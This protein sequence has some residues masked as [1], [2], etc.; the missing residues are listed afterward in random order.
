VTSPSRDMCKLCSHRSP[1]QSRI[2]HIVL[3]WLEPTDI[4]LRVK[5]SIKRREVQPSL[6][7][8]RTRVRLRCQIRRRQKLARHLA[9]NS[10]NTLSQDYSWWSW[11]NGWWSR[12]RF[13][14][15]WYG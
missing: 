5:M 14:F 1:K 15:W 10:S 11:S 12:H 3:R 7:Q 4:C 2:L 8:Q 13:G 9:V 6:Y